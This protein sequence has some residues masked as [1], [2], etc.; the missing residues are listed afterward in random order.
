MQSKE[1]SYMPGLQGC[2]AF[3]MTVAQGSAEGFYTAMS[4]FYIAQFGSDSFF[5]SMLL[6]LM[7][8]KPIM[9]M[10][11]QSFDAFFDKWFSTEVTYAFRVILMQLSLAAVMLAWIFSASTQAVVLVIGL[12]VGIL[13]SSI[14]SS[15][16]Q[17]AS[18]MAPDL[19]LNAKIGFSIGGMAPVLVIRW[20]GF[21]PESP[22]SLFQK[23]LITVVAISTL[24]AGILG[25]FHIRSD[26][27]TKAY[28]RLA[29]DLNPTHQSSSERASESD[30]LVQSDDTDFFLTSGQTMVQQSSVT[31]GLDPAAK[32]G[33]PAWVQY[34]QFA[35]FFMSS[36]SMG[37]LSTAGFFKGAADAQRL[38]LLKLLMELMGRVLAMAVPLFPSFEEGPF[39]KVMATSV[40]LVF[41]FSGLCFANLSRDCVPGA[42]FSLLWC[43]VF[44]LSIFATSLADVTT[45][46]YIEV[47]DRKAV[48]RT[49]QKVTVSAYLFGLVI[50]EIMSNLARE[51]PKL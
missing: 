7:A 48:A 3:W 9:S 42:I 44:A 43:G 17:M 24:A 10:L 35:I 51:S 15:S 8:P 47:R 28:K 45:G 23:Q 20:T 13:G 18:A 33:V 37:L 19:I 26:I 41:C 38:S 31:R 50:S 6:C 46:A 4:G 12:L 25:I 39:H 5:I 14:I 11:Q 22:R 21:G 16:L 1:L 40:L 30:R 49:N 29:Y 27:F 32:D 2:A 36:I 34:W